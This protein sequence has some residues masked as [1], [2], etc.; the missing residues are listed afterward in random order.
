MGA[1]PHLV[2]GDFTLAP[3]SQRST[4]LGQGFSERT[5]DPFQYP[6]GPHIQMVFGT[7]IRLVVSDRG[8]VIV[9][10][11]KNAGECYPKRIEGLQERGEF[12]LVHHN[13]AALRRVK[14]CHHRCDRSSAGGDE[15]FAHQPL[16]LG[17]KF[18]VFGFVMS[19]CGR[20]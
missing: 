12:A 18:L 10:D 11:A 6:A 8:R 16:V 20:K 7:R 2:E 17:V 14:G 13:A 15:F 4:L 1:C 9:D 19:E 5:D 3:S